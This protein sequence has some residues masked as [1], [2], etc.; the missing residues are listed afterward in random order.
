MIMVTTLPG[1]DH[2]KPGF[3]G[4]PFPGIDAKVVDESGNEVV[5]GRW[6]PRGHEALAGDAT[7]HLGRP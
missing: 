7:Q 2:M 4:K 6:I 5:N 1:I 3:A